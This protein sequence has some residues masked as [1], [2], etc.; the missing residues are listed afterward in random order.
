MTDAVLNFLISLAKLVLW[1][2]AC[3]IALPLV[4]ILSL[5]GRF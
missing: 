1:A 4:A 3:L 2:I 5:G